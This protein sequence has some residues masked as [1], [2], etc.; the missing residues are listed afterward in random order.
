M[1]SMNCTRM[2]RRDHDSGGVEHGRGWAANRGDVMWI[3]GV[4]SS[5]P[6][7]ASIGIADMLEVLQ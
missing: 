2:S 4:T 3:T 5:P 6:K 1:Q 7:C